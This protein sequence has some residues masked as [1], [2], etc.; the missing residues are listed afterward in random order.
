MKPSLSQRETIGFDETDPAV[1]NTFFVL[2]CIPP[3]AAIRV[4]PLVATGLVEGSPQTDG[5]PLE[6]IL[7][8]SENVMSETR[9]LLSLLQH[10]QPTSVPAVKPDNIGRLQLLVFTV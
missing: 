8:G 10:G 4:E 2:L 6:R 5:E 7:P 1:S 9:P 3:W